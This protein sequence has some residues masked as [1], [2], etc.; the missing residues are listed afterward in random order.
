MFYTV[1]KPFIIEYM[2]SDHNT[3]NLSAIHYNAY[4][5]TYDASTDTFIP[6]EKTFNKIMCYNTYQNTGLLNL[7]LNDQHAN[8]YTNVAQLANT[9]A[10][11]KTDNNFKVSGLYDM[12]INA[13]NLSKDWSLT[14]TDYYIDVVPFNIDFN[15]SQ[16]NWSKLKDK[17]VNVRLYYYPDNTDSKQLINLIQTQES[18]SVR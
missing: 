5:T 3:D 6:V 14:Q 16:Y 12:S 11:I 2:V 18:Y 15:K 13:N 4:C 17:F 7:N 8:P 1:K 10:V 9:K